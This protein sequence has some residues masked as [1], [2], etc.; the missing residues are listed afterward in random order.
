[1]VDWEAREMRRL[2]A[3]VNSVDSVSDVFLYGTTERVFSYLSPEH[4]SEPGLE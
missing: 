4:R 1:M 3:A 2:Y